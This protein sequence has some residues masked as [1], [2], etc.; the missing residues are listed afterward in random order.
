MAAWTFLAHSH[1]N[2]ST[3]CVCSL[4]FLTAVPFKWLCAKFENLTFS[5]SL[6]SLASCSL[7]TFPN[8]FP[9]FVG[10]LI[11]PITYSGLHT[12]VL[13]H[14]HTPIQTRSCILWTDKSP[15]LGRTHSLDY[16]RTNVSPHVFGWTCA[17]LQ[18]QVAG[19]QGG[20]IL[21]WTNTVLLINWYIWG[22][23]L[24]YQ[25]WPPHFFFYGAFI[26][27]YLHILC[28]HCLNSF[29]LT[30]LHIIPHNGK[31]FWKFYKINRK[32]WNTTLI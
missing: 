4:H 26:K 31:D 32:K 10:P 23:P 27:Y 15:L 30:N 1:G 13:T 24:Q 28:Y 21:K 16:Y 11:Y 25:Q 20:S 8:I 9:P 5:C 12:Q 14:T 3:L 19:C 29:S 18:E 6:Y 7:Q 22:S 2:Y 17:A